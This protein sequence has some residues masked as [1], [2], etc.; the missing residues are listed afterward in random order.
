MTD[1]KALQ[2]EI[3]IKTINTASLLIRMIDTHMGDFNKSDL[4]TFKRGKEQNERFSTQYY[5]FVSSISPIISELTSLNAKLASLLIAAD[6]AMDVE[7]VVAC[8]KR[9]NAFE[10][11]ERDLYEYT[12]SVEAQLS[13]SS[14]SATFLLKAA[15]KFK[16]ASERLLNEN[17]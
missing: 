8:E 17:R 12:S 13:N 3:A 5:F 16:T 2:E 9:F 15:Q 14:A 1:L 11:F 10:A 6:K 4:I 7:L